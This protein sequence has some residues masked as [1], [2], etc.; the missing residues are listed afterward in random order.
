MCTMNTEVNIS[1]IAGEMQLQTMVYLYCIYIWVSLFSHSS[2]KYQQATKGLPA[3]V[4]TCLIIKK[5]LCSW[6]VEMFSQ[7]FWKLLF[8]WNGQTTRN[9]RSMRINSHS[10]AWA[11]NFWGIMKIFPFNLSFPKYWI[12]HNMHNCQ[13]DCTEIIKT[14]FNKTSKPI[15]KQVRLKW[16]PNEIL[17]THD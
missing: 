3:R 17:C 7:Q 14:L 12:L 8:T 2:L 16:I 13:T 5:Q 15:S 1:T 10:I 6:H 4:F 11:M 9:T